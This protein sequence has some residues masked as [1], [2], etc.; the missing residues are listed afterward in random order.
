VSRPTFARPSANTLDDPLDLP[1]VAG[2]GVPEARPLRVG[3]E[4]CQ[5]RRVAPGRRGEQAGIGRARSGGRP[6]DCRHRRGRAAGHA[7]SPR[8]GARR[9]RCRASNAHDYLGVTRVLAE[10]TSAI[11]PC[12]IAGRPMSRCGRSR[13]ASISVRVSGPTNGPI[14]TG[15]MSRACTVD[16]PGLLG[17]ARSTAPPSGSLTAHR[18]GHRARRTPYPTPAEDQDRRVTD[19]YTSPT[20][21]S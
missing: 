3:L 12:C 5:R 14:P 19:S 1:G 17:V 8:G 6:L 15:S 20:G 9:P 2:S 4:V 10:L 11:R 21:H 7:P 13:S 18:S 16:H